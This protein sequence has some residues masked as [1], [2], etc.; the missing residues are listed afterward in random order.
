VDLESEP[1]ARRRRGQELEDAL[2]EAAWEEL[3]DHGYTDFTF[4]AVAERAGTSRPV[5]N[6]RWKTRVEIVLAAV[7][8]NSEKS[9]VAL[10]DTGTL[11]GDV[12][13]LLRQANDRSLR[14]AAVIA[15]QLGAYF[16]ETGTAPSDLRS[17]MIGNRAAA[18]DILVRRAMDRGEIPNRK[19][20][21]RVISLPFDLARHE[22]LMT[23]KPL[24]PDV[25]LQIV[26]EIF[27]PLVST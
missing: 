6:R 5:L 25:I 11:R 17:A 18:M 27:L 10:P 4:E 9:R 16:Q 20:P 23:L 14:T 24:D 7:K 22:L 12:I 26:D 2:L 21:P 1:P 15:V 3:S 8:H 13:S 19:L